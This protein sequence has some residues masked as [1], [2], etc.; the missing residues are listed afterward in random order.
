MKRDEGICRG[1]GRS[2]LPNTEETMSVVIKESARG[3]AT[4]NIAG[5][6][7][8]AITRGA[9]SN[10]A[11]PLLFLLVNNTPL[12]FLCGT[13]GAVS[14]VLKCGGRGCLCFKEVPTGVSSIFGCV[15][16]ELAT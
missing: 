14:S 15:P 5:T 11:T 16:T 8:R 10:I 4:R 6:T 3:L 13:I 2:S 1:L 12:K 7:M 9:S